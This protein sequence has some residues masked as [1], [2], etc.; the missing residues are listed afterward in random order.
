MFNSFTGKVIVHSES[1]C[2]V[3]VA[4]VEYALAVSAT[5][6]RSFS[7][8]SV[9]RV[10]AYLHHKED[11][12]K[13]YGFLDEEEREVFLKLLKVSGVGPGLAMK[14]LSGLNAANLKAAIESED[15]ASLSLIPGLGKKTAQK[16]ILALQGTIAKAENGNFDGPY[17]DVVNA[18][19]DMGF[20]K[21]LAKDT[22]TSISRELPSD[23]STEQKEERLLREAIVQLSRKGGS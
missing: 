16:I 10:V 20:D 13:L 3:D 2:T 4:G 23:L 1:L 12:M 6:A 11:Q 5:A 15:V 21:G 17:A 22:V 7:S 8:G 18:L 19:A 14:I 9:Q